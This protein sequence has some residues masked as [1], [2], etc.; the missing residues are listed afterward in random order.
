MKTFTRYDDL[1]K[2]Y[3]MY[4]GSGYP[5]GEVDEALADAIE[6]ANEPAE[7]LADGITHYFDL[8]GFDRV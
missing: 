1:P 6:S 2:D 7:L 4:L 8:S 3:L 5:S